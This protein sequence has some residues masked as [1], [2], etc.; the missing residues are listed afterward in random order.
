MCVCVCVLCF[1]PVDVIHQPRKVRL[2]FG[3]HALARRLLA[4]YSV[5]ALYTDTHR[6]TETYKHTHRHTQTHTDTQRHTQTHTDTHRHTQTHTDTQRHTQ[7]HTDTH[8]HTKTH[9]DTQR[10]TQTHCQLALR[11]LRTAFLPYDNVSV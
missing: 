2:E 6:H 9:T 10:H 1:V 4:V 7:T 8:R 5:R 11:L 3:A